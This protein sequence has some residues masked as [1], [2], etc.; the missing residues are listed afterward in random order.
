MQRQVDTYRC[1][2]KATVDDPAKVARFTTFVNAEGA[3]DGDLL[4]VEERG[5]KRPARPEE[6]PYATPTGVPVTISK[7]P[8]TVR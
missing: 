8:G 4:Y 5:Q 1:E 6:R 7:R 2:W 3:A